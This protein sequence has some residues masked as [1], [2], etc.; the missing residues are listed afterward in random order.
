VIESR[1]I[2]L[3]Q[4]S[5]CFLCH[6]VVRDQVALRIRWTERVAQYPPGAGDFHRAECGPSMLEVLH[7]TLGA[8][9]PTD[10]PPVRLDRPWDRLPLVPHIS[11]EAGEVRAEPIQRRAA[12]TKIGDALGTVV[13]L[14][15]LLVAAILLLW[16]G[17]EIL[18][19]WG[20]AIYNA[21]P[22]CDEACKAANRAA[23]EEALRGQDAA[24]RVAPTSP[25]CRGQ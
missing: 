5:V 14:I 9:A 1:E 15:V 22:T 18:V 24:C 7:R 3:R 17:G 4:P 23:V 13:A 10:T 11:P 8:S 2:Q 19:T 16:V 25:A 6:N 21:K 12:L 20:T